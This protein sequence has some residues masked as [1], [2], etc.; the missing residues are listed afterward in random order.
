[1]RVLSRRERGAAAGELQEV[2]GV[3]GG[4]DR[5]LDGIVAAQVPLALQVG[6]SGR[7][8]LVEV[9]LAHERV[10]VVAGP[11]DREREG[12]ER[13]QEYGVGARVAQAAAEVAAPLFQEPVQRRVLDP[14]VAIYPGRERLVGATVAHVR[15]RRSEVGAELEEQGVRALSRG[16]SEPSAGDGAPKLLI[17][18][19]HAS[20]TVPRGGR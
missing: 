1:M 17:V 9:L 5:A 6:K 13:A 16:K 12:G 7:Q 11:Q 14:V 15:V 20:L 10:L 2:R 4:V 3:G 19:C 18:L 8:Q